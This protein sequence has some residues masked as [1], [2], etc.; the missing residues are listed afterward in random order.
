MATTIPSDFTLSE[1]MRNYAKSKFIQNTEEIFE[2]FKLYYLSKGTIN[3]NW[4]AVWKKW[5]L[6]NNKYK[7][8]NIH[9]QT[10][11]DKYKNTIL[12]IKKILSTNKE[13]AY[14]VGAIEA[15]LE[16][17]EELKLS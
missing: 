17:L 11:T 15:Q 12:K 16:L 13:Y 10:D 3:S 8:H 1:E 14:K 2:D 9:T 4:E 5:V 7:K 6:N